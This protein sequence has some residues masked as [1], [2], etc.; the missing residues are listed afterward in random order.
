[1]YIGLCIETGNKQIDILFITEV[2]GVDSVLLVS[3][4]GV[5]S[6]I[7]VKVV[8]VAAGLASTQLHG[9]EVV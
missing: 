7:G 1:L 8:L 2:I 5:V 9:K 4:G 3:V 6:G